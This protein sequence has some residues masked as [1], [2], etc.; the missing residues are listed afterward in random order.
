MKLLLWLLYMHV[1]ILNCK[2][3]NKSSRK[4]FAR[5]VSIQR[6]KRKILRL[7][8]KK[9]KTCKPPNFVEELFSQFILRGGVR[10]A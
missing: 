10:A 1:Y 9:F 2:H 3:D 6:T 8:G 4:V 5:V 7:K